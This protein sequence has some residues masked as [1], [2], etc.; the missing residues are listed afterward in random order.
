MEIK[1]AKYLMSSPTVKGCPAP[2]KPEFAFV[3]R[4]NVGKSSLINF[5]TGRKSLALTSVSPG[6]TKNINHFIINDSW[7]LVDLPGYGFA[8]VSK[9]TRDDWQKNLSE[10]LVKR[11]NLLNVF[12]L[13]DVNIPPQQIDLEFINW[14]GE[15]KI[16]FTIVFTKADKPNIQTLNNNVAR[17]LDVLSQTWEQLPPYFVTSAVRK[18]GKDE[19]LDY[20]QECFDQ[21]SE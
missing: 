7:Y 15:N 20:I 5:L 17:F 16:P 10:Y 21:I 3:G 1:Q 14:M 18:V 13:I 19:I 11:T 6:K 12:S 2:D 4:S 8:K 9:T